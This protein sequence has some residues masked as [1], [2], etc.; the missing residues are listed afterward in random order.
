MKERLTQLLKRSIDL[1]PKDYPLPEQG[2][3][4][5]VVGING[6]GSRLHQGVYRLAED[7]SD[8]T[9][10]YILVQDTMVASPIVQGVVVENGVVVRTVGFGSKNLGSRRMRAS[11]RDFMEG[12]LTCQRYLTIDNPDQKGGE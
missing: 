5:A 2:M 8:G 6:N 7:L 4:R 10:K 9:T 11:V 1:L 12:F 3:V